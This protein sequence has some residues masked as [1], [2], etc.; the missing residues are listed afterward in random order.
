VISLTRDCCRTLRAMHFWGCAYIT[1]AVAHVIGNLL[2]GLQELTFAECQEITDRGVK[3]VAK[4][5]QLRELSLDHNGSIT[6]VGVQYLN[7][8][9]ALESLQLED[10]GIT[11]LAVAPI[12]RGT[13][14]LRLVILTGSGVA[15][16]TCDAISRY[17]PLLENLGLF[18]CADVT[19][20][21]V[22]LIARC[23]RLEVLM[24]TSGGISD[25]S[26]IPIIRRC[27]ALR[28]LDL[29]CC[30][31]SDA[32]VDQL[33]RTPPRPMLSSHAWPCVRFSNFRGSITKEKLVALHEA[34]P[35]LHVEFSFDGV[36][37]DLYPS[38]SEWRTS[39]VIRAG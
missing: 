11:D 25:R 10:R 13:S 7:G 30:N 32:T 14:R 16:E 28:M 29:R 26:L 2:P 34:L 37:H 33:I 5:S 20:E 22:R 6:D 15:D 21:G 31:L 12:I 23:R 3:S 24:A 19:D 18:N 27:P 1:D 9:A 36:D 35:L 38:S 4:C 8:L 17:C 39:R